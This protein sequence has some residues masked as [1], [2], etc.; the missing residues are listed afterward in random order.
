MWIRGLFVLSLVLLMGCGSGE[1]R[2]R[3]E[4]CDS[5]QYFD[6]NRERC[7]TCPAT[8][9][10]ECMPGCG[11]ESVQDNRGCPVLRCDPGCE[12]CDEGETWNTEEESCEPV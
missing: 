8:S 3:P 6:E 9:E 11:L 5:H 4:D 1:V 12:G 10:P 7:R 2:D